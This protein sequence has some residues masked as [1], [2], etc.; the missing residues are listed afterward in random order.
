MGWP[1][2][3]K[4]KADYVLVLFLSPGLGSSEVNWNSLADHLTD[5][6]WSDQ[7]GKKSSNSD[8]C[9]RQKFSLQCSKTKQEIRPFVPI[10]RQSVK[11]TCIC[12]QESQKV[13]NTREKKKKYQCIELCTATKARTNRKYYKEVT[14][15]CC[16]DSS[17]AGLWW[18]SMK[19]KNCRLLQANL[20]QT[21][22]TQYYEG[23]WI[24][25]RDRKRERNLAKHTNKTCSI[26]TIHSALKHHTVLTATGKPVPNILS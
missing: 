25:V 11:N 13:G 15:Y 18:I 19:W 5:K 10:K 21:T 26:I 17:E 2:R 4:N 16:K 8:S 1:R 14:M 3:Q 22:L 24:T 7:R 6:A 12:D 20:L 23:D 9:P